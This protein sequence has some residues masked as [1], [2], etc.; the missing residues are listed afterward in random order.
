MRK[1]GS[2]A[3]DTGPGAGSPPPA[4]LEVRHTMATRP[5]VFPMPQADGR[6]EAG[7]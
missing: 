2:A 4:L 5:L 6:T 7:Q 1:L 3:H